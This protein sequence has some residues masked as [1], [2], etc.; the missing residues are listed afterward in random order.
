MEDWDDVQIKLRGLVGMFEIK[1]Q[2]TLFVTCSLDDALSKYIERVKLELNKYCN[3]SIHIVHIEALN[4]YV[5]SDEDTMNTFTRK[6]TDAVPLT[7]IN[8]VLRSE[9]GW[10]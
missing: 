4:L 1:Y 9:Y 10:L 6:L 8:Q 3:S 7:N 5:V 2:M